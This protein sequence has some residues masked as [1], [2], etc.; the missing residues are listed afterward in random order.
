L[1]REKLRRDI[2]GCSASAQPPSEADTEEASPHGSV[3]SQY[4]EYPTERDTAADEASL[5]GEGTTGPQE[6]EEC[7]PAD[8][9]E[10]EPI[11]DDDAPV[12]MLY[13]DEPGAT[14]EVSI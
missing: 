7:D 14:L 13:G 3:P 4:Q 12:D 10:E 5:Q 6:D 9:L 2:D 8:W 1:A 11:D